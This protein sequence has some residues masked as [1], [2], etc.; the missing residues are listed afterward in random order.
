MWDDQ[1][2]K[3]FRSEL[4][5]KVSNTKEEINRNT[6]GE[7]DI[8]NIGIIFNNKMIEIY[9]IYARNNVSYVQ[10]GLKSVI[11]SYLTDIV[12]DATNKLQEYTDIYNVDIDK[13]NTKEEAPK[14]I[15]Q[16]RTKLQ[17]YKKL[18]DKVFEF[19]INRDI[20]DAVEKDIERWQEIGREGGYDVYLENP[21]EVIEHYNQELE[22]L[23]MT[24]RI[25]M[26]VVENKDDFRR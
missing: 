23:G 26:S 24:T 4:I 11:L 8:E 1:Q 18:T 21:T 13:I 22:S 12:L 15:A 9:Q 19:D 10:S 14:I 16:A 20:V 6:N 7:D 5:Q 2:E 25:P 3:E 17:E